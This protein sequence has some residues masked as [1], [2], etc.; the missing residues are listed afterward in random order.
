MGNAERNSF[1]KAQITEATIRLMAEKE[2]AEISISE[3]I[4]K[5][6]VSRNSFYRNY[7]D[8]TDVILQHLRKLYSEWDTEIHKNGEVS[9]NELYV[10]L[11]GHIKANKEFYLLLKHRGLFHLFLTVLNEQN[12]AQPSDDNL[13]AYIKSYM[14]YG[15]FGW[16]EE[17]VKRG[18][19]ESEEEMMVLL[20]SQGKQQ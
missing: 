9:N 5:A 1:V 12:G 16:I 18:M 19:Q 3:I 11:F 15:T 4:S 10:S 2:L 13:W 20:Q 17:W 7:T 6:E 8:K 14:T